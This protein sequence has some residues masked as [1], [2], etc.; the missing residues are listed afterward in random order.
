MKKILPFSSDLPI[1]TYSYFA[2]YLGVLKANGY[3]IDNLLEQH[4]LFMSYI[5]FTG[6]VNFQCKESLKQR[7]EYKKFDVNSIDALDFIKKTIINNNYV[8]IFLNDNYFNMNLKQNLGVH[9]WLVYGFDDENEKVYI[10]GYIFNNNCGNYK[11]LTISYSEFINSIAKKLTSI[12]KNRISA[13]HIFSIPKNININKK[14]T[15][16]YI[17]KFN[18]YFISLNVLKLLIFHNFIFSH[19]KLSPYKREFI[20]LRDLRIVYE[21]SIVF[22]NTLLKRNYNV[23]NKELNNL[24]RLSESI[25][26]EAAVYHY[27][28]NR[29]SK[30]E[31][32]KTIN[33][34][35]KEIYK[36]EKDLGKYIFD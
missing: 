29:K 9:N 5:P 10:A 22:K 6:Q 31:C 20:D 32:A 19:L 16:G 2:D 24:T 30:V 23:L 12:E 27:K 15:Y 18:F 28:P 25:L 21:Q 7:M 36:I 26:L 14:S 1:K 4:F 8:V 3:E 34:K 13:N 35:I 17:K 33:K 11:K